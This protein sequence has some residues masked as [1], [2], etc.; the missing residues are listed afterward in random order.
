M[1][2]HDWP[3]RSALLMVVWLLGVALTAAMVWIH[4]WL[5]LDGY[6]EVPVIGPLPRPR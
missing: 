1:D 4:L 6:Q 5:W 3:R 2:R